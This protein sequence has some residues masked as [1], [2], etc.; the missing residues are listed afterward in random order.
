M[1][2]SDV[3]FNAQFHDFEGYGFAKV[4]KEERERWQEVMDGY[5]MTRDFL[6]LRYFT[7]VCCQ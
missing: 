7:F 2:Y 5:L 4:S 1:N 3:S 6:N